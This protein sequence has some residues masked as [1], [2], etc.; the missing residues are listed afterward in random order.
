MTV[1]YYWSLGMD[2]LASQQSNL[3]S[4]Q[5]QKRTKKA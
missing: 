1:P 5:Y 2:E 4:I 3:K